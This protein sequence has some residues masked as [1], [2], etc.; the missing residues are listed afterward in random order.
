MKA[1]EVLEVLG[2]TRQTLSKYV[3]NGS[4]RV[5][6]KGNGQYDYDKESVYQFLNKDLE[7]KIAI[8]ARVSTK[9]QKADL[10]N[11]IEIL[12]Q[13]CF[14]NGYS[15]GYLYSDIASGISFENRKNFFKMLDNIIAGKINKVI[16]SYKDRLSRVDFGLFK[17]LFDKYGCEIVVMSEIGNEK[18]DSQEIFE[19]II[20][21]LHCY[22]MKFYS[23]RKKQRI[24]EVL[25]ED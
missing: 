17:H 2:V 8:Y 16:I 19:E 7:R 6:V 21:L 23:S 11:Q 12:K 18:L 20:S 22:S 14:S 5:T 4:I 15:I 25:E 24:K 3:K 9:K 10:T 13:F 1:N